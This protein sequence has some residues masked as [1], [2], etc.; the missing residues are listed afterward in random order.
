MAMILLNKGRRSKMSELVN[1][2]DN[3]EAAQTEG[4][5]ANLPL[6]LEIYMDG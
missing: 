3:F 5:T 2:R 1:W 6:A 4:K